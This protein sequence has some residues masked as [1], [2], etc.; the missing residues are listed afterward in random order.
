MNKQRAAAR[1]TRKRDGKVR[2]TSQGQVSIPRQA[3]RE[4]GLGPGDQLQAR[5]EAPGRIVF[6]VVEDPLLKVL[7]SANGLFDRAELEAV[8]KEW[9]R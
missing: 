4:A 1:T 2:I 7:G 5:V 8:R 6:E 3:M 9:D